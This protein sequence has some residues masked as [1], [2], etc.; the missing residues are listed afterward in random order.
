M[1]NRGTE[2]LPRAHQGRGCADA[3]AALIEPV[4]TQIRVLVEGASDH[5]LE[6]ATYVLME[7][8]LD[9]VQVAAEQKVSEGDVIREGPAL[10]LT[11][12]DQRAEHF[13]QQLVDHALRDLRLFPRLV[14]GR[15]VAQPGNAKKKRR[16]AASR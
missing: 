5:E 3:P 13:A 2:C 14:A 16:S 12:P 4:S 6:A 8:G 1:P 10:I 11:M 9:E 7:M 15:P